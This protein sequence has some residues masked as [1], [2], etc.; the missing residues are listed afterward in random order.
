MS[1]TVGIQIVKKDKNADNSANKN[2]WVSWKNRDLDFWIH[3]FLFKKHNLEKKHDKGDRYIAVVPK[4]V[5]KE[6]GETMLSEEK[7]NACMKYSY[8]EADWEDDKAASYGRYFIYLAE[9]VKDDEELQ[10]YDFAY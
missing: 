3:G 7:F 9:I 8:E 4:E 1:I 10:Y 6:M 5:L 2:K